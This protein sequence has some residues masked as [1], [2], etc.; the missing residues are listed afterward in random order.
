MNNSQQRTGIGEDTS[1]RHQLCKT[2]PQSTGTPE[3]TSEQPPDLHLLSGTSYTAEHLSKKKNRDFG[4]NVQIR[5]EETKPA[6][7]KR[8]LVQIH[9]PVHSPLFPKT[10]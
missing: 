6:V 1:S 7:G 2:P 8:L 3:I 9:T 4:K 10:I 5:R